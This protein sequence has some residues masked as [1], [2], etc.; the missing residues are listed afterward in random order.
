VNNSDIALV[1]FGLAELLELKRENRFKIL[2]YRKA[3]HSIALHSVELELL[4]KQGCEKDL[5]D[6]PGVGEA[7]AKKIEELVT[8][9]KLTLYEKLK[10]EFPE[11]KK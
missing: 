11:G 4:V 6:I 7:I 1:F 8:T 3:A 2:A 10:A 9:G 5:Q